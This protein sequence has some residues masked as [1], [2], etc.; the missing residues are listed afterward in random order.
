M[1]KGGEAY[2][3]F[4]QGD[5]GGMVDIIKLYSDGL[6][7]YI[8]E[9]TDN[10]GLAEEIM[11]E[12]FFRLTVKKPR[13]AGKSSFKTWLYAIGRNTAADCLR[14]RSKLS[15]KPVDEYADLADLKSLEEN[16]LAQERKIA[17]HRAMRRLREEYRQVLYLTFFEGFSNAETARIMKKSK[18]QIEN[19]AYRA[20]GSLRTELEKEGITYEEL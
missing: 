13:F 14:K 6:T 9:F 15:D 19:L 3:R 4:L 18:R 7:L 8:N 5:K 2:Y 1:D 12:V 17:L 16:Y 11:E 10:I 20:K